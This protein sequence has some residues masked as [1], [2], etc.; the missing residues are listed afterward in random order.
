MTDEVAAQVLRNNYLQSQ[1][2]SLLERR[3]VADL[4]DH[5]H[6][7]RAFERSG[8]LNR[9]LEFL[10]SDREIDERL[11]RGTGLTR[12]ELAILLAYGKI[13]MNH[14]LSNADI[15]SDAYL[16][17]ELQR[18]FPRRWRARFA[19]R[20]ARHRLRAQLIVT[21]TTNSILNRMDPGFAVRM[22]APWRAPIPSRATAPDCAS[23]GLRSKRSTIELRPRPST[24]RC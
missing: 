2:I 15:S 13:A 5:Q 9:A 12:P 6:L 10:P 23:C 8:A 17:S 3:S 11:A 14:A 21:A 22:S 7:L 24:M 4:A 1:A 20:I 18:Y 19:T 16:G